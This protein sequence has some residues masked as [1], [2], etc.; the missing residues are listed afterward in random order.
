MGTIP[1][2]PNGIPVQII[3]QWSQDGKL[4]QEVEQEQYLTKEN[5]WQV[6]FKQLPTEDDMIKILKKQASGAEIKDFK[7]SVKEI[8]DG[9]DVLKDYDIQ[10]AGD[11][12][13]FVI[14]NT[15]KKTSL[16]VKKVWK[17]NGVLIENNYLTQNFSPVTVHLKRKIQNTL[18]S[19][20]DQP[21]QLTYNEDST[22]SWQAKVADLPINDSNNQAYIYFIEET[23]GIE[24]FYLKDYI[25][26]NIT[27]SFNEDE[28]KIEVIN[29]KQTAKINIIKKW[30]DLYGKEIDNQDLPKIVE[31][32]IYRTK[33]GSTTN[34][35]FVQTVSINRQGDAA[36]CTWQTTEPIEVITKYANDGYY[37]YY[38]KEKSI[39]GYLE[40]SSDSE[41]QLT[42]NNQTPGEITFTLKNKVNPVYPQTGGKGVLGL[43]VIGVIILGVA[44]IYRKLTTNLEEK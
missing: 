24:P 29:E 9:I 37:T 30:F 27:L 11:S 16:T 8:T 17:E 32:D 5:D 3:S 25:N 34:G 39:S 31:V 33:D 18:D 14:T 44:N 4:M 12:S 35:E 42:F 7:Y 10:Y 26:N 43:I 21:I 6:V 13:N 41:K 23:K 15:A 38:L 28:N 19:N 20:F 1:D 2:L 40:I 36:P 22:K